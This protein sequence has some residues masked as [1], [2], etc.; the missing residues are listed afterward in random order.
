MSVITSHRITEC[1]E[2][3]NRHIEV[4]FNREIAKELRCGDYVYITGTIYTAR[5]RRI[6]E[7]MK[8]W[9]RDWSFLLM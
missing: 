8:P 1:E 3:M 6:R 5:M 2:D 7:C 4:P 9:L